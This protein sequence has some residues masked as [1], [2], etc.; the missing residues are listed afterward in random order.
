MAQ[1]EQGSV[2][3]SSR[4]PLLYHETGSLQQRMQKQQK[5]LARKRRHWQAGEMLSK[6]C[7]EI[8]IMYFHLAFS[9]IKEIALLL[10]FQPGSV[11]QSYCFLS[12]QK[13]GKHKITHPTVKQGN[14]F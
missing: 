7:H 8:Q 5:R 11:S 9:N 3:V 2:E 6:I 4:A 13:L 14:L 12:K 1:K 10:Y